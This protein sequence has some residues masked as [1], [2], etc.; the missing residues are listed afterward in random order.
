MKIFNFFKHVITRNSGK[1]LLGVLSI[2]GWSILYNFDP[3]TTYHDIV[4]EFQEGHIYN[5]VYL[6]GDTYK[7]FS[8]ETPLDSCSVD[9]VHDWW[10][11]LLTVVS[12]ILSLAF[13]LSPLASDDGSSMWG[14]KYCWRLAKVSTVTS[15]FADKIYYYQY[16][17]RL[18]LRSEWQAD[19]SDLM[20]KLWQYERTPETFPVYD[21]P[22]AIRRNKKLD[23]LIGKIKN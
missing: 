3:N 23:I 17:G 6:Q 4:L 13:L 9:I 18:L 20:D 19:H 10:V 16:N 2:I 1:L 7:I 11:R 8:Q 12:F 22:T 5:Y 15:Y 14:F 21:G